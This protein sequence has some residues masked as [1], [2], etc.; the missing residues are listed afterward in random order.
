MANNNHQEKNYITEALQ[1]VF[2]PLLDVTSKLPAPLA[3][4]AA[5]VIAILL[6]FILGAIIP[7]N[8]IWLIGIIIFAGLVAFVYIDWD[9]R[10]SKINHQI[11]KAKLKEKPN[12]VIMH[13]TIHKEGDET[14]Y[15]SNAEVRLSLPEPEVKFSD[16]NGSVVF[17][18]IPS[19]YVG[20]TFSVNVIKK[21]YLERLPEKIVVADD[22]SILLSLKPIQEEPAEK[23][24]TLDVATKE[25]IPAE[26][27]M[28]HDVFLSYNSNDK[29]AVER[30]AIRLEDEV[31]LS[32]FLDKWNLIPGDPW[33]ED[34]EE[35]LGHSQTIAVF[36][37]ASGISPWHNE[38]MRVALS[39]R[40][41]DH[42]RRVIPVLLPG[43]EMPEKY[44]IPKFLE[45]MTW[46]DFRNDLDD[47]ET[48]SRFVAGIKGRPPER[49]EY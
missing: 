46:V 13:F 39:T 18:S 15:I 35:A 24:E 48:F 31:G 23:F 5:I 36:L 10:H 4:G 37:G 38:E 43:T 30:L 9:I 20:K 34:L 40:V 27:K 49:P 11:V 21:G 6:T 32:V 19:K 41:K 16:E 2:K 7:N 1:N 26:A 17:A 33:Q 12:T 47:E 29:D 45:R 42:T 25:K 44:E 8:L 14:A 3:Y 28:T 22:A